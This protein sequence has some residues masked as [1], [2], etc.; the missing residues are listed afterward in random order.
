MSVKMIL[1]GPL[2]GK[3]KELNG[4][5]F[6]GG[7]AVLEGPVEAHEGLIKYL[8]TSYQAFPE[9][10]EALAIAQKRDAEARAAALASVSGA[11]KTDVDDEDTP[12]PPPPAPAQPTIDENGPPPPANEKLI[13]AVL[14]VDPEVDDFWLADGTVK[15]E[16]V[17]D[18][19]GSAGITR[20]DVEAA[21]PGFNREIARERAAQAASEG[22]G[23]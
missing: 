13:A 23:E 21:M 2:A 18:K 10:S 12:P 16:P 22:T 19:Y 3:T 11:P 9:G 7:E 8:G 15:M 5:R 20:K 1:T 6:K 14:A 17:E 4:V